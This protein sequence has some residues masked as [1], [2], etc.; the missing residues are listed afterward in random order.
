MVNN[1]GLLIKIS[2]RN[3]NNNIIIAVC[4]KY[5]LVTFVAECFIYY[6]WTCQ[7]LAISVDINLKGSTCREL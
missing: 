5:K 3:N 7:T 6:K 2:R 4:W 1:D